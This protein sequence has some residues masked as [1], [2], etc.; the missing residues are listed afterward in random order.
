MDVMEAMK[1]N[2]NI[3]DFVF[4]LLATMTGAKGNSDVYPVIVVYFSQANAQSLNCE[5]DNIR[6][7][8]N[9]YRVA[10]ALRIGIT[11]YRGTNLQKD[12]I[13][14]YRGL[15]NNVFLDLQLNLDNFKSF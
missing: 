6:R 2:P 13:D 8:G 4:E 3:T 14:P 11:I 12:G 10:D 1:D 9:F 15:D 7:Y 5:A